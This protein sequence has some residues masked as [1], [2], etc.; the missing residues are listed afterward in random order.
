MN[1]FDHRPDRVLGDALREALSATD[2]AAFAR[3]VVDRMP[4]VLA[5]ESWWEVLGGWARP[6]VAAAAAIL[7]AVSVWL[8]GQRSTDTA[9][10]ETVAT[11]AETTLT[12]GTLLASRVLPEFQ[13]EMVLGDERVNE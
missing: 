11:A 8:S 1:D 5:G 6:G 12:A 4:S 3:R 9:S 10:P 7:V 2:D 13:V